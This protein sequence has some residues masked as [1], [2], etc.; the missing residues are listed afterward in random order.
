[1][2]KEPISEDLPWLNAGITA[3][4]AGRALEAAT[5]FEAAL[6]IRPDR[7]ITWIWQASVAPSREKALH[8]LRRALEL[9]PQHPQA[10][11]WL[12]RL[13][14]GS[15]VVSDPVV[16]ATAT[17]GSTEKGKQATILIVDDSPTV[18]RVVAHELRRAG[19]TTLEANDGFK[20]LDLL[21]SRPIDLVLLDQSMPGLTGLDVC[22][23]IRRN[24][25]LSRLPVL[26]ISGDLQVKHLHGGREVGVDAWLCKPLNTR[27]LLDEI[28]GR[29]SASK[30]VANQ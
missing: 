26:M 17:K 30:Q 9:E 28:Q 23:A 13:E 12:K 24:S 19:Y 3:A 20:G 16:A 2:L 29:L 4:R 1:M 5:L 27:Q 22:R 25:R 18:C 14:A 10:M 8:C 7:V 11:L 15:S 6:E 21:D